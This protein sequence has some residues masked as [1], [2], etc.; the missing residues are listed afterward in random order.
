MSNHYL[1]YLSLA[2]VFLSIIFMTLNIIFSSLLLAD[3]FLMSNCM[4]TYLRQ[5]SVVIMS[6]LTPLNPTNLIMQKTS[7]AHLCC[8]VSLCCP[9]TYLSARIPLCNLTFLKFV[10][11]TPFLLCLISL[12]KIIV[13]FISYFKA[14]LKGVN[15]GN[16]E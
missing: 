15:N 1:V 10:A 14:Y 3:I 13:I 11:E 7:D 2:S 8:S 12:R 16:I 9:Y 5:V 6:E 4:I